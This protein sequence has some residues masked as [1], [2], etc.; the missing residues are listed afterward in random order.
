MPEDVIDTLPPVDLDGTQATL[1]PLSSQ[2]GAETGA[3][4]GPILPGTIIGRY[5]VLSALGA[6]AMGIVLAAYDPEL[7]RKVALSCSSPARARRTPRK[8]GCGAR[9]RRWPS[10]ITPTS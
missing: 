1:S 8:R 10:S 6:G 9:P 3:E 5:V 7:D 2:P 4:S